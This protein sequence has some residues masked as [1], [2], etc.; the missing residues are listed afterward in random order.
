MIDSHPFQFLSRPTFFLIPHHPYTTVLSDIIPVPDIH[1]S[2]HHSELCLSCMRMAMSRL[3]MS[4]LIS[5][6]L[7]S[8]LCLLS[9]TATSDA[10]F[11]STPELVKRDDE[12][13]WFRLKTKVINGGDN[14]LEGLYVDSYHTGTIRPT[15]QPLR[16]PSHTRS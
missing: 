6:L 4:L 13:S 2:Y 8:V 9:L 11:V 1:H 3:T 5:H 10:V 14:N 7:F 16:L 15:L 12:I